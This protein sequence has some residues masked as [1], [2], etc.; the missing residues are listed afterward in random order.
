MHDLSTAFQCFGGIASTP[1][2]IISISKTRYPS[3]ARV[4][5][6]KRTATGMN[7]C[8][9]GSLDSTRGEMSSGGM[10]VT[11]AKALSRPGC[12]GSFLGLAQ[13]AISAASIAVTRIVRF[14]AVA[15]G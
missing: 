10:L 13:K 6:A 2:D 3:R 1:R 7:S 12:S 8:R 5:S 4:A 14:V 9:R 11:C 15:R